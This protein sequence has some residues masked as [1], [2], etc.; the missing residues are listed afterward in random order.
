MAI[1]DISVAVIQVY[2]PRKLADDSEAGECEF[3]P[4]F[5]GVCFTQSFSLWSLYYLSF[6]DASDYPF[7]IFKLFL[8]PRNGRVFELNIINKT[9]S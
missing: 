1:M 7:S 4:A 6:F 9:K 2:L 3:I 8:A 5:S